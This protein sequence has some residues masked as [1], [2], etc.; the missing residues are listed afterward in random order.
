MTA[1]HAVGCVDTE[2][3]RAQGSAPFVASSK[4]AGPLP[5]GSKQPEDSQAVI[6][7]TYLVAM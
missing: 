1:T 3:P 5:P 6:S 2:E 4:Q 7:C